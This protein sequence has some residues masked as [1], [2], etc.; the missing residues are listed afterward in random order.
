MPIKQNSSFGNE[1]K[2]TPHLE[3]LNWKTGRLEEVKTGREEQQ[4]FYRE[5]EYYWGCSIA[6]IGSVNVSG[7][8]WLVNCPLSLGMSYFFLL[9]F[10]PLLLAAPHFSPPSPVVKGHA[11]KMKPNR[12][13]KWNIDFCFVFWLHSTLGGVFRFLLFHASPSLFIS[14]SCL[15]LSVV[16]SHN[17]L[18]HPQYCSLMR[19]QKVLVIHQR[20]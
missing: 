16:T 6:Q 11:R 2:G 17:S 3:N 19:S 1:M 20:E 9:P 13:E 7:V 12:E 5:A 8:F 4:I 15:E 10:P 18:P 14:P